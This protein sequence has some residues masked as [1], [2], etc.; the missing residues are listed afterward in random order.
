MQWF[1]GS[2]WAVVWHLALVGLVL[3]SANPALA[4]DEARLLIFLEIPGSPYDT[5]ITLDGLE[6]RWDE[7]NQSLPLKPDSL[8]ARDLAGRQI[9]L[10]SQDVSPGFY[11]SL[12]FAISKIT[13][14]VGV[15]E[16]VPAS[17]PGGLSIPLDIQIEADQTTTIFLQW[18]PGA[19]DPEAEY[20]TPGI[21][22]LIPEIPPLGS[23][24][25]VSSRGSGSVLVL[26]RKTSRVVS[27]LKVDDD[28][29][30]MVYSRNNQTLY[31]ALADQD[32]VAVVDV[33]SLRMINSVPLQFGDDPSR[34][35]LSADESVLYVLCP[36]SRS[37]AAV[38]AWSLQQ[39]F[40]LAVGDMPRSFAQDP[41]TGYIYVTCED[42]GR[43]Q[44]VD[45]G[46]GTISGSLALVSAPVEIVIDE[47][48]R[49]LYLGG[50]AQR[51]IRSF[52]LASEASG[53]D[54]NI[55]GPA[56]GLAVNPKTRRLYCSVPSCRNLAVVRPDL[57]IEFG[58]IPLPGRPGLMA[59]DSEYRQL[60]VV[61]PDDG[62]LAVCNVNSSQ[63]ESVI[64]VDA[65]PYEVLVP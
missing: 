39:Q 34:L 51:S 50:S 12:H 47:Q 14:Q 31:I 18:R 15:A 23:L 45:P 43:V 22:V 3:V 21:D 5:E 6:L 57:G 42:E 58:S 30:G 52:N 20:H 8:V 33:L 10:S 44:I 27:A 11:S 61:L 36:G 46:T 26:N 37:L 25:F 2:R 38:T 55:C 17:P 54:I 63:V 7:G 53:G 19:I 29:R 32:A 56:A 62:S 13:G 16:V 4:A 65:D 48:S 28:P 9:L 64:D 41:N 1:G 35:L 24:A 59:F 40:R 49:Q 60:W